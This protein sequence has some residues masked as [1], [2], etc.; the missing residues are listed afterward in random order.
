ML[1]CSTHFLPSPLITLCRQRWGKLT[2]AAIAPLIVQQRLMKGV[3]V[4]VGPVGFGEVKFGVGQLPEQVVTKAL[5]ATGAD[6]EVW[7]WRALGVKVLLDEVFVDG[8]GLEESLLGV[9]CNAAAGLG[10]FGAATVVDGNAEVDALVLGGEGHGAID[11]VA[12]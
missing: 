3:A 1:Y 4:K 12:E 7:I 6:E 10:K 5:F 11:F 2:K 8:V 9:F